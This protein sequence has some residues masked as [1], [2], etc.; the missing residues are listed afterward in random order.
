MPRP[1]IVIAMM[2]SLEAEFFRPADLDRLRACG[3]V[4]MS[5]TPGDHGTPD[6]RAALEDAEIVL[7]GW[8]TALVSESVLDHAPRVR[9]VV[10]TAGSVRRYVAPE[11]YTRGVRV[12]SQ[13][14][15]NSQP[16]AEYT[17][18]MIMLAAKETLRA[19]RQYAAT[20]AAVDRSAG[21]P[22]A[23]LFGRRIG[24]IGLSQ[25]SRRV[26]ALLRPFDVE[27]LVHSRHLA[28]AEA[29]TLGVRSV[30]LDELLSSCEV[31]SLHSASLPRT[32]HLI[33]ARELARMQDRATLINT[34]RGAIVDQDALIAELA[35]GRIDA[36]LDVA[37]PD[38]TAPSSPLW[39]MPN[40]LLTPHFAGAVGNELHRLGL[41]AVIDVEHFLAGEPMPGEISAEQYANQ[42]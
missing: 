2:P 38:V 20:R 12:A 35:T 25:I 9:V 34:A 23:G 11:V 5:P 36:I 10:H 16:V 3:D 26:I 8:G 27:I 15:A 18:A 14:A 22:R 13:T 28:P 39:D 1:K 37:E 40:V 41:H 32:R 21:F 4:S 17:A 33:G 6:A 30:S 24:L 42:A 19:A 31:V 29:T 7:T